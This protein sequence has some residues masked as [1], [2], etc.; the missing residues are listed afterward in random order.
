V[1]LSLGMSAAVT[2]TPTEDNE[3]FETTLRATQPGFYV[4][5]AAFYSVPRAAALLGILPCVLR[6]WVCSKWPSGSTFE[7]LQYDV[8]FNKK[9]T[10]HISDH[11]ILVL[12]QYL[13]RHPILPA[14]IRS[15]AS[16]RNDCVPK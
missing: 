16:L 3:S 6:H 5:G 4:E 2:K 1:R 8:R 14:A 11:S 10:P 12:K 13:E 7:W 9:R 15:P